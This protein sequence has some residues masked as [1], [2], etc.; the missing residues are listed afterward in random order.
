MLFVH[1]KEENIYK[2]GNRGISGVVK[3]HF[4]YKLLYCS[5]EDRNKW[6]II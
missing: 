3:T 2:E 4:N 5:E 1:P 6:K